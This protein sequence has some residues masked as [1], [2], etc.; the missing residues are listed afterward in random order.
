MSY[1][2]NNALV[3]YLKADGLNEYIK[4]QYSL[5]DIADR[6]D[7][8]RE[9]VRLMIY[10]LDPTTMYQRNAYREAHIQ[11]LYDLCREGIAIDV[12]QDYYNDSVDKQQVKKYA[13]LLFVKHLGDVD[14]SVVLTSND[15][16]RMYKRFLIDQA[17]KQTKQRQD[18][19]A[20]MLGV[21]QGQVSYVKKQGVFRQS[22]DEAF[23][24]ILIRNFTIKMKDLDM[25]QYDDLIKQSI[26][27]GDD[28]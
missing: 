13:R 7:V 5:T 9:Y 1:D 25:T 28:V 19:I 16:T 11:K 23:K 12:I 18:Q 3:D 20:K 17:L 15:L 10:K 22:I 14:L 4:G 27:E 8:S 21:S 26:R 24:K 6:F 2:L